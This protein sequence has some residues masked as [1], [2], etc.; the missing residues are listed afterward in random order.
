MFGMKLK[1]YP[2]FESESDLEALFIG[3][4]TAVH[5]AV[6]GEVLLIK[7]ETGFHAFKNKCPHQGKPL[8]DC[9]IEDNSIVCAYHRN[10][11]SIENGRGSGMYIDKYE[12]KFE[13]G[14][15]MIG[16]EVWSFF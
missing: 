9:W 5:R 8:N 13:D 6:F 2:L 11:F 7:S 1:W 16:K 4:S 3:K 12:L 14:K 15:V 10:H